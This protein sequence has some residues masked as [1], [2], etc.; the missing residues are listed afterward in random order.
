[1]DAVDE[2][3]VDVDL[4]LERIHVDDG[5]DAGAGEAAAGG[6]RRN[7][8]AW[9]RVLGGDHAVERRAHHGVVEV[10]LRHRH[11]PLGHLDV[12]SGCF[13]LR[14]QVLEGGTRRVEV[15]FADVVLGHQALVAL[16]VALGV[17][18]L[19]PHL[20]QRRL[21]L[22]LLRHRLVVAGVD[23]GLVQGGDHLA[24]LDVLAFLDQHL[25][26]LVGDLR[27]HGGLAP[28]HHVA[29]GVEQRTAGRGAAARGADFLR[30]R[31]LHRHAG[32]APQ[33]QPGQCGEHQHRRQGQGQ[34]LEPA[35]IGRRRRTAA[36]D[37]QLVEQRGFIVHVRGGDPLSA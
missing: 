14:P 6:D 7:D 3:L 9:L 4:H 5:A 34:P 13:Q 12:A 37:A 18:Q 32:A 17:A 36:V 27:R 24:R 22:V 23:I 15:G 28:R 30:R 21:G 10:A 1:M 31:R 2:A 8:L 11:A 16:V 35:A 33:P 29:R 20:G 19:H 25:D 26:H